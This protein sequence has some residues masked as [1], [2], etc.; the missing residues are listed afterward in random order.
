MNIEER[1]AFVLN[2]A[3]GLFVNGQSTGG[4]GDGGCAARRRTWGHDKIGATAYASLDKKGT[5]QKI[6]I[7]RKARIVP[8]ICFRTALWMIA[9]TPW[10]NF[11]RMAT[12]RRSLS[13]W[14]S[15]RG[16]PTPVK[17]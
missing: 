8:G 9:G 2:T 7:S 16:L 12:M 15:R 1:S 4:D 14:E 3:K 13:S 17:R 11:P 5:E 6:H 10:P